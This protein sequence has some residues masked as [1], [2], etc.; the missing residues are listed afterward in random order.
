V[1]L[2]ISKLSVV[3]SR[4]GTWLL[5]TTLMV[6]QRSPSLKNLYEPSATCQVPIFFIFPFILWSTLQAIEYILLLICLMVMAAIID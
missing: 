5:S 6:S 4:H 1:G 3:G 2:K